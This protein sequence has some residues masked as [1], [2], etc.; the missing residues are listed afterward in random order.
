MPP[1]PALPP[2]GSLAPSS[3]PRRRPL[4][5]L[6]RVA[7]GS[8]SGSG[9]GR[10]SSSRSRSGFRLGWGSGSCASSGSGWGLRLVLGLPLGGFGSCARLRLWHLLELGP[11][12][13]VPGAPRLTATT[14]PLLTDSPPRPRW[15]PCEQQ[16]AH[17]ASAGRARRAPRGPPSL[18]WPQ[19]PVPESERERALPQRATASAPARATASAGRARRAPRGPPSLPWPQFP[20][21]ESERERALPQ[22]AIASAPA[23][24]TRAPQRAG[25]SSTR[26]AHAPRFGCTLGS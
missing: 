19:F 4:P 22:R 14:L 9:S 16:R 12:L 8:G 13:R 23:R 10:G 11:P 21:P 18:P 6:L 5:F 7:T 26:G 24:S 17:P 2:P 15:S 20:V 25:G 3:A 1:S